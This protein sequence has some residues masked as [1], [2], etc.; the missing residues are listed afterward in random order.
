VYYKIHGS[1]SGTVT[2]EGVGVSG[3]G[4]AG[5]DAAAPIATLGWRHAFSPDLRL[6]ADLSGVWKDGGNIRGHQ[7]NG[8]L[9]AEYFP[10]RNLGFAL[11]YDANDLTLKSDR[12]TWSGRAHIKFY[13]PAAYVRARF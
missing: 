3:Y 13:G 1:I 6:Y 11:E 4:K 2:I 9:G 12:D 5:D 8:M 10:W 7:V